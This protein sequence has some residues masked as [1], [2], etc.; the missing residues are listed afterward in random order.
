MRAARWKTFFGSAQ[1][2]F[3]ICG[4]VTRRCS[5]KALSSSDLT[6]EG[7]KSKQ[8]IG[9]NTEAAESTEFTETESVRKLRP[10]RTPRYPP[11]LGHFIRISKQRTCKSALHKYLILK[12]MFVLADK[13]AR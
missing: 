2:I 5:R 6:V 9:I 7:Q 11:P 3:P 10:V 12:G 1:P 13:R 8:R 4:S